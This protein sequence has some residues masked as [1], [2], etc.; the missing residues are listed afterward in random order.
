M[1]NSSIY[2]AFERMWQ[3]IVAKIGGKADI[4]H[5]HNDLYY[6]ETE[7]DSLLASK[8][9]STHNHDAKYDTKGA[10]ADALDDAKTYADN[11][12]AAVKNDLL[13]GAGGAYDTLKELGD[14][15]DDNKD[16]IDAL[17]DIA[18]GKADK[19]HNH[20]DRYYTETEVDDKLTTKSDADH[21]HNYYG[22]CSTAAGTAAKAVDIA[23]F[24]LEVGAMVLVKFTEANSASNPT[25]NVSGTGAK[26]MYRYGTTALS[27][28]TTTTGWYAGSVQVFVYDGTG[29]IRDYW[30]NSAY[31]N[32]GLG[33]GY[34]T[35]STAAAT[36]AKTA[37]C[38]NYALSTG[39]IVSVKFTNAV[40]ANAT[41]N[42]AS[43]GAKAMY[44]RG[45][46]ITGDV[47]KAGDTATF[48]YSG[49]YYHLLS[50]DRWQEDIVDLKEYVDT[51][52]EAI[53][54]PDMSDYETKVDAQTK[55]DE[56]VGAKA[57]WNQ[58]DESALDYVKNRTH[59]VE[60]ETDVI[61]ESTTD[62][63]WS[64]GLNFNGYPV[65]TIYNEN[66]TY[67]VKV[68]GIS[69][70]C[71][72][73][74]CNDEFYIGDSR[75]WD[76]VDENGDDAHP[77]NVPFLIYVYHDD[78]GD[79]Y[80]YGMDEIWSVMYPDSEPHT[81]KV[82]EVTGGETIHQLDE[83]FIPNTI[84]RVTDLAPI[85]NETIDAICSAT[86]YSSSEVEL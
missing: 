10:A 6:T 9:D 45:V 4:A 29:W 63:E 53:P 80:I 58:N 26:P 16:A 83:K 67:I 22:V 38:S 25:L 48:I 61:K 44:Y 82:E 85:S 79:P 51:Q 60:Q 28:G 23:G 86:I 1:T 76:I 47:I 13:N 73:W 81:I 62:T 34:A 40:P 77:E 41:L 31:S 56:I 39:G 55:Y 17:E 32:A 54:T 69:Y 84:A 66:A 50:I 2:A 18:V 42:I 19:E 3:H 65:D 37:T 78:N 24:K 33:Q 52:I 49:T 35:C 43:K 12:A 7:V 68:D 46:A 64:Y 20:D 8:S 30:N 14:L 5:E 11:A 70:Q 36:V 72:P 21:G 59:W 57:D 75:L 71:I 27:T 15:I 74:V